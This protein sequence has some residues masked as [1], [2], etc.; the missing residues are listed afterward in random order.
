MI[1]K[2]YLKHELCR[3]IAAEMECYQKDVLLHTTA[4]QKHTV[5]NKTVGGSKRNKA[6]PWK[7]KQKPKNLYHL[8]CKKCLN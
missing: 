3:F 2:T 4:C 5:D 7:K 1:S 8:L 6:N